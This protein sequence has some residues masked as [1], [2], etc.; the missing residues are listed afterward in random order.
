M[1]KE[2]KINEIA[3]IF[4]KDMAIGTKKQLISVN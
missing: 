2:Q 4:R 3:K 1:T